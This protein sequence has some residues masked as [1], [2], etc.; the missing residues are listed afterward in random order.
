[1]DH[2]DPAPIESAGTADL[3]VITQ[4][5]EDRLGALSTMSP[6]I[7]YQA[8]LDNG[9]VIDWISN[10]IGRVLGYPSSR[11]LAAPDAM[12]TLVHPDDLHLLEALLDA[13][14]PTAEVRTEHADGHWVWL[15]HRVAIDQHGHMVGVARDV[16]DRK[17]AELEAASRASRDD[18]THLPNGAT[19]LDHLSRSLARAGRRDSA[20]AVVVCVIER[21]SELDLALGRDHGDDLVRHIADVLRDG[22]RAG[23]LV[24]R[25]AHDTFAVV[26]DDLDG[27][28]EAYAVA[29][30]IRR[31]LAAANF[32]DQGGVT[33]SVAIGV[34]LADGAAPHAEDLLTNAR[35]AGEQA[36][37][38]GG[39]RIEVFD[40]ALRSELHRRD[41]RHGELARAIA[42]GEIVARYQPL[43]DLVTGSV[44][45]AEALARWPHRR[46][47]LMSADEFVGIAETSGLIVALGEQVLVQAATELAHWQGSRPGV[48]FAMHVNMSTRQLLEHDVVEQI[49]DIVRATGCDPTGLCL[50]VSEAMLMT[51]LVDIAPRLQALRDL[52]IKVAI[53]DFGTGMSS[54]AALPGL[55]I[56][57][58]KID[59]TFV[60]CLGRSGSESSLVR[61]IVSVAAALDCAVIGEGVETL[62]QAE[63]LLGAGCPVAQGFLFS[64]AVSFERIEQFADGATGATGAAPT[65]RGQ[66]DSVGPPRAG[67]PHVEKLAG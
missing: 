12:A 52:G 29:V 37:R 5:I 59:P 53:D 23:D 2:L 32:D 63:A 45:G 62:E 31:R 16:S 22:L 25:L 9:W 18:V 30:R 10:S 57:V 55:P 33:P 51:D 43:I 27:P 24:A 19:A 14:S 36:S 66:L 44:V 3:H 56:D 40:D 49:A 38:L 21:L 41:Q 15:E 61:A 67:R 17:H 13:T 46:H 28:D 20:V 1:M 50:E 47:G 34:A 26:L 35:H 65:L 48:P 58:V 6:D 42:A 11:F 64:A 54:L 8:Q 60:A 7:I 39:N 4:H